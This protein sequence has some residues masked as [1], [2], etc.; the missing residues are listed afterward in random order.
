MNQK[1]AITNNINKSKKEVL[2]KFEELVGKNK[3]FSV[4]SVC[5]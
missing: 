1:K 5:K 4:K 3:E 2:Q